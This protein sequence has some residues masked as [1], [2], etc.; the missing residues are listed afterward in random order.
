M[1]KL[2]LN[3]IVLA[4]LKQ[5]MPKTSKAQLA[6]EKYVSVLEAHLNKSLFYTNDNRFKFFKWFVVSTR[7]I[8]IESGQFVICGKKQYLQD[9]LNQQKLSLFT[10]AELGVAGQEYSKI[11]LT[12]LVTLTDELDLKSLGK[13]EINQ[14]DQWLNDNNL[15]DTEFINKVFPEL[16]ANDNPKDNFDTVKVDIVSLKRYITWII[17]KAT[18]INSIEKQK[19]LRQA[20]F[21][22][23]VAQICDSLFLQK[24]NP[25]FFGRNYYHGISI[26]SVHTSLREAMLGNCYEYDLR[27]AVISWKLGF[28]ESLL[29]AEKI[30][31]DIENYFGV[32]IFYLENKKA[33]TD[34]VINQTFTDSS[35]TQDYKVDIIKQALTALSFGARMATHGWRDQSGKAM[36][37]ALVKIIKNIKERENFVKCDLI[38]SF[39]EEQK[40]LDQFIFTHFTK[41]VCPNLLNEPQLQTHSGRVSKSKIMAW[42]FQH[43]ET[44]IMDLVAKEVE[45][46]HNEVIAR[47]HDAIFV[48]Y[49]IYKYQLENIEKHICDYSN[50]KY[51]KLKEEKINRY[52]GVSEEAIAD[53][54]EHKKRIAAQSKLA[55]GYLGKFGQ[56]ESE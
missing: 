29:F 26:Q 43:A 51:W 28:A 15:S 18:L 33:F 4:A 34:Y 6:L 16:L 3:P 56:L 21:I 8:M 22:L 37:P 39:M 11:R 53:E 40:I 36:N 48:K 30:N 47:V 13:K 27:S 12:N 41:T 44:H 19:I 35:V 9:W 23:R 46:S 49:K 24:K 55:E 52:K 54:L 42:L 31:D 10:I 7:D 17:K 32:T 45:K 1:I 25:S 2:T 20:Y 14:I 5:A 50:I 38:K